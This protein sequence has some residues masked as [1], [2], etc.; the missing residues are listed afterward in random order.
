MDCYAQAIARHPRSP[1]PP[2]ITA[3][4]S[5]SNVGCSRELGV[6]SA[7]A[8]ARSYRLPSKSS[9]TT[10]RRGRRTPRL[11]TP[12]AKFLHLVGPASVMLDFTHVRMEEH[13]MAT[14]GKT[15]RRSVT[16]ALLLAGTTTMTRGQVG[17]DAGA[18][19]GPA[20]DWAIHIKGKMI[21]TQ[22]RLADVQKLQ[23]N[24]HQ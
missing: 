19:F 6:T 8:R 7:P 13:S 15:I 14:V 2:S 12:A 11:R 4:L 21:C 24:N 3:G 20:G 17:P 10:R 16:A 18:E 1:Q 23:P 5:R 22:C 9:A